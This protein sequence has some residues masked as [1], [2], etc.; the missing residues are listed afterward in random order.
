MIYAA[1][2]GKRSPYLYWFTRPVADGWPVFVCAIGLGSPV[3]SVSS[4]ELRPSGLPPP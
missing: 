2:V 4:I 1:I 3:Y